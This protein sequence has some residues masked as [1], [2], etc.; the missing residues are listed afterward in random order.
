MLPQKTTNTKSLAIEARAA[1]RKMNMSAIRFRLTSLGLGFA[2]SALPGC[3]QEQ[4][5]HSAIPTPS[6]ATNNFVIHLQEGFYQGRDAVITVDGREVYRG[7]PKT[8]AVLGFAGGVAVTA[9]SGQ[10]VVTFSMPG[11][12]AS[13]TQ[14][15]DL[16]KGAA[17]G[18]TVT[19]SGAVEV[20]QAARFGYE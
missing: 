13:W 9:T 10:P 16:T 14:R 11:T 17:L 8:G 15:V 1:G 3:W 7:T 6:G 5:W 12:Q 19:K 2:L 20:R 18:I 4:A